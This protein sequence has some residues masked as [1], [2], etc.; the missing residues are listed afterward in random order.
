MNRMLKNNSQG[1]GVV[2]MSMCAQYVCGTQ[3]KTF[4]PSLSKATQCTT[5]SLGVRIRV[6]GLI[7]N[8]STMPMDNVETSIQEI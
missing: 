1:L 3:I 8:I 5:V 7:N 4:V 2:K 6:T